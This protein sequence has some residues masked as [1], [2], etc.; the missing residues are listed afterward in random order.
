MN[1]LVSKKSYGR[2]KYTP[3]QDYIEYIEFIADSPIYSGLEGIKEEDGK[4][5][6]QCSSGKTTSFYKYFESRKN[7]WI[8][9]ANELKIPEKDN[10]TKD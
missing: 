3:S 6:W 10:L 1:K 9:K 4:I 8:N 7:W 2:G 5:N